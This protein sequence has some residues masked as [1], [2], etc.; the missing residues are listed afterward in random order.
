MGQPASAP[1]AHLHLAPLPCPSQAARPSG[2]RCSRTSGGH[3]TSR[4]ECRRAGRAGLGRALC[5]GSQAPSLARHSPPRL[6]R[7]RPPRLSC[8]ACPQRV[9]GCEGYARGP[10][11]QPA[12]PL[13]RPVLRRPFVKARKSA[14]VPGGRQ[15][16]P[17]GAGGHR[18][19]ERRAGQRADRS[20]ESAASMSC[21]DRPGGCTDR[22]G[23]CTGRP[24]G[25]RACG[26]VEVSQV[27]LWTA[28]CMER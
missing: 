7:R 6:R 2:G 26:G 10:P 23:G 9:P 1:A 14:L 28:R 22:P 16:L 4:C 12:A 19:A 8:G 20:G 18:R 15:G 24:G 13:L 5:G 3:S 17:A 27:P 25:C 11:A 21:T